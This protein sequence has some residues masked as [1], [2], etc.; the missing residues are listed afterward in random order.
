MDDLTNI[1]L[2]QYELTEAI[3]RGG[4]ATV[5]KAYQPSLDRFVA[6]K[7]MLPSGDPSFGERFK[8]EARVIAQLEH[9][10]ILPVYDYGEAGGRFFIVFRYVQNGSSLSDLL[11]QPLPLDVALSLMKQTLAALAYAHGRG[12]VHRDVKP[13]NI[14]LPEPNL[15]LL[16]DFGL[17]HL[18]Q[19]N[20]RLT[21]SGL[22]IGTPAYMAPEQAEGRSLDARTDLYAA[23]VV[24]YEMLTGRVPFDADTPMAALLKTLHAPAAPPRSINPDIPQ[25]VEQV[26]LRALEKD[27]DK[28]YQSATEMAAALEAAYTSRLA[29]PGAIALGSP[30]KTQSVQVS[31]TEQLAPLYQAGLAAFEQGH[32]QEAIELLT[33]VTALDPAFADASDLLR[34]AHQARKGDTMTLGEMPRVGA[35]HRPG[36]MA[37]AIPNATAPA[38]TAMGRVLEGA[39]VRAVW[40]SV[41]WRGLLLAGVLA[42]LLALFLALGLLANRHPAPGVGP[43][44]LG[45][46]AQWPLILL[47]CV[48]IGVG[49]GWVGWR[50]RGGH[51]SGL[52]QARAPAAPSHSAPDTTKKTRVQTI[53]SARPAPKPDRATI[54]LK[55]SGLISRADQP[56]AEEL[57]LHRDYERLW[58]RIAHAQGERVLLTGYGPFGA[59]SLMRCAV[60]KAR[61]ELQKGG[62]DTGALLVFYFEI[63]NETRNGFEIKTDN[64]SL[65]RLNSRPDDDAGA[66]LQMHAASADITTSSLQRLNF[67]LIRP[68][69]ATFFGKAGKTTTVIERPAPGS[70]NLSAFASELN[71]FFENQ[72]DEHM[73]RR[74]VLRLAGSDILPSRVVIIIDKIR[75]MET[76]EMLSR[77]ELFR[78]QQIFFIIVSRKED[79]IRWHEADQRLEQIGF[80]EWYIPCLWDID[81]EHVLFNIGP[82]QSQADDYLAFRK[83]LKYVGRGSLGNIIDALKDSRNMIHGPDVAFVDLSD[84]REDI[85]HDAWMQDLLDLNWKTILSNRFVGRY[86]LEKKDRACVAIYELLDWIAKKDSFSDAELLAVALHGPSRGASGE[87]EHKRRITIGDDP[88]VV[89]MTLRNLLHVLL[90]NR[91]LKQEGDRYDVCWDSGD[92]PRPKRTP[93]RRERA[94]AD[95]VAAHA[96]FDASPTPL[97]E[98]TTAPPADSATLEQPGQA[99]E[100]ATEEQPQ[101]EPPIVPQSSPAPPPQAHGSAIPPG[102]R[103]IQITIVDGQPIADDA[104]EADALGGPRSDAYTRYELGFQKLF[105]QLHNDHP[106]YQDAL[107]Y[108]QRLM[109]SISQARRFGDTPE[110]KAD[111]AAIVAQLNELAAAALG[112]SFSK[113]AGI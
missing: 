53:L 27:S 112:E 74:I 100:P 37:Q 113:L 105:A 91:Y 93:R 87:Q 44:W 14:L 46:L 52:A 58:N 4:M 48:I 38:S 111:R 104:L 25:A 66:A 94:P 101:P 31:G 77:S 8:R 19:D 50:R 39:D 35:S 45:L 61:Y 76:F 86:Q 71:A 65:G 43:P 85:R 11:G 102:K 81:L 56:I 22:V 5:Y 62:A 13:S 49:V 59:T 108:Q 80:R 7:V 73:L 18:L 9:P 29:P 67:P 70:Y 90:R 98:G 34:A 40:S 92:H 63:T 6:V 2:G 82:A 32:W 96:T 95:A 99:D 57:I 28:R 33:R 42:A 12:I 17:A 55:H 68:L 97:S 23:G 41:A 16:S 47:A 51:V 83:H 10:N 72:G 88:R 75:Y 3:G 69:G 30:S 109:E 54:H 110:H 64:F 36:S 103:T 78:N 15:A 60:E 107:V 106:R 20:T 1:R 21:M 24:L 26:I 89:E 84:L 79:F